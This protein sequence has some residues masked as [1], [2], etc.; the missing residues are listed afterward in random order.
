MCSG[1]ACGVWTRATGQ[2]LAPEPG[3]SER[4][5]D[6]ELPVNGQWN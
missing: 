1:S 2:V 5:G 6:N 3:E 4:N